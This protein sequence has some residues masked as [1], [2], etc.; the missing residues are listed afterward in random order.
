MSNGLTAIASLYGVAPLFAEPIGVTISGLIT[1][2]DLAY[3]NNLFGVK[4]A[5]H[6]VSNNVRDYF[7][8]ANNFKIKMLDFNQ[9]KVPDFYSKPY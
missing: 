6:N 9:V 5:V 7:K 8:D 3:D 1:L 2:I 4:D